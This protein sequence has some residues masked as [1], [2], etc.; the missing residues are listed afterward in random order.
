MLQTII[1]M[2]VT[3]RRITKTLGTLLASTLLCW[4]CAS[5]SPSTATPDDAQAGIEGGEAKNLG[6]S[7]STKSAQEWMVEANTRFKAEQYKLAAEL[8]QRALGQDASRLDA[9][10]NRAI[11]LSRGGDFEGA[12]DTLARAVDNGGSEDPLVYATLGEVY[13]R[14]GLYGWAAR[15]YRTSLAWGSPDDYDTLINLA[16]SYLLL[17]DYQRAEATYRHLMDLEPDDP[18]PLVGLGMASHNRRLFKE[19]LALYDRAVAIEPDYAQAFYN[20]ADV[21]A[22]MKRWDEAIRD[23]ETFISLSEDPALLRRAKTRIETF[24]NKR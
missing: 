13:H 12:I 20:R 7:A 6:E 22:D 19:A 5:T 17:K 23:L 24:Q 15:A 1:E 14:K 16:S 21:L 11:A 8:Y 2:R 18:R 10:I 9:Y 3:M 4:G